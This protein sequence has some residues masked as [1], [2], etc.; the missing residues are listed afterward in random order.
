[1]ERKASRI[2]YVTGCFLSIQ[3]ILFLFNPGMPIAAWWLSDQLKLL[4]IA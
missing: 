3:D 2:Q 1:M 4:Q